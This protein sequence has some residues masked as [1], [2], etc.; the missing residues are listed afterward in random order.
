MGCGG[1]TPH[2]H[3][4]THTHRATGWMF[5][6]SSQF[7]LLQDGVEPLIIHIY[8]FLLEELSASR[9]FGTFKS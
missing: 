9:K 1:N 4:H 5:G 3:T 8:I 6:G 2:T 7:L